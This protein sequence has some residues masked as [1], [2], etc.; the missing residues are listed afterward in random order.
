MHNKHNT[1]RSL[2]VPS[3]PLN[4][5]SPIYSPHRHAGAC[6][7]QGGLENGGCMK[8]EVQGLGSSSVAVDDSVVTWGGGTSTGNTISSTECCQQGHGSMGTCMNEWAAMG[9]MHLPQ[10]WGQFHATLLSVSNLLGCGGMQGTLGD[11]S[12]GELPWR[13][14]LSG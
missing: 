9:R 7:S 13:P 10:R 6:S 3:N 11:H 2:Q 4:Y 5:I 12:D 8:H 1:C 14:V